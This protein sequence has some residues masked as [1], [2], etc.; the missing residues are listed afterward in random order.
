MTRILIVEDDER[1]SRPVAEDLQNQCYAV[2]TARDGEQ[3]W[4]KA[5]EN[6]YD[7]IL[8]DWMLPKL[9][10]L[11]LCKKLRDTDYVGAILM[12]TAKDTNQDKIRGLDSGADDYL[13]KP[14]AIDELSAR[15]RAMLRRQS[16]DKRPILAVGELR[17]DP[18]SCMV[19]FGETKV[20]VTPTEYRLLAFFLRNPNRTFTKEELLERLWDSQERVAGELIKAHM[21][22]LRNHLKKAGAPDD[23]IETVHGL[24]Y[25]LK[26]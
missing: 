15:V 25:R 10:G 4:L 5:S 6:V 21:K 12:L 18:A 8:L 24:G 7:L 17:L 20:A 2:D 13:I 22:G 14:F 9:D 3:G 16:G 23:I 11:S 26:K 1:I 19:T